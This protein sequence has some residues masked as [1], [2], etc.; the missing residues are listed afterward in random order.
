MRNQSVSR[1][2][3]I[4]NACLVVSLQGVSIG[5]AD[6]VADSGIFGRGD[7][8]LFSQALM[9][10]AHQLL[11]GTRAGEPGINHESE[12]IE[13]QDITPYACLDLAYSGVMQ[14]KGVEGGEHRTD[15]FFS[16]SHAYCFQVRA[17]PVLS[18][19][20][21]LL[22]FCDQ[23]SQ[24]LTFSILSIRFNRCEQSGGQWIY[25][26]SLEWGFLHITPANTLLQLPNVGQ[27]FI[28][29]WWNLI[30][31]MTCSQTTDEA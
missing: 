16:I 8:S 31:K 17:Q 7:P 26:N 11:H 9:Y 13:G 27:N 29:F 30:A 18:A 4:P 15:F 21:L 1:Y 22:D 3:K 12:Q 28:E 14:D 5:V 6:G 23:L 24:S 20:M 19:W 2:T 25:D 10:Y